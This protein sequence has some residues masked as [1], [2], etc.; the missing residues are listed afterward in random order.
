MPEAIKV[1]CRAFL[2]LKVG[3]FA[4]SF[5]QVKGGTLFPMLN[6]VLGNNTSITGV[7]RLGFTRL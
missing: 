6:F 2:G 1:V 5:R 4:G 3:V 7:G